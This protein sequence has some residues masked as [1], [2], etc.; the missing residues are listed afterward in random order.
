MHGCENS[1]AIVTGMNT[2]GI[3]LM[4]LEYYAISGM[5][6]IYL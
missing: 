5:T 4:P 6:E 2:Q 1:I 3:K